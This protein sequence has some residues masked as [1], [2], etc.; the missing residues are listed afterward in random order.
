MDKQL[1]QSGTMRLR[2]RLLELNIQDRLSYDSRTNTIFM[3]YSG[4]HVRTAEDVKRIVQAVDAILGPLERRVY[5]VVNYDRFQLDEVAVAPYADA[6]RYVQETY[7]LPDGV[8][9]HSTNAFMILKLGRELARR[10]LHPSI[11]TSLDEAEP[12]PADNAS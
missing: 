7:Y 5:S 9:R 10:K 12:V 4:M 11:Y 8:T 2:H 3:D 6:V 1:F